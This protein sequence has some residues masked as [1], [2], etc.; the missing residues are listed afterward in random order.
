VKCP[1]FQ[2]IDDL[3]RLKQE[4]SAVIVAA[5]VSASA[6]IVGPDPQSDGLRVK[7]NVVAVVRGACFT[8]QAVAD[9]RQAARLLHNHP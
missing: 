6:L 5:G 1:W 9:G 3:G 7:D 2:P 8:V 4:Y